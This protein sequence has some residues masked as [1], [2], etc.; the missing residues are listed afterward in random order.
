MI[1][2]KIS[3]ASILALLGAGCTPAYA[4]E[5]GAPKTLPKPSEPV[6]ILEM[7]KDGHPMGSTWGKVP[8]FEDAN[9]LLCFFATGRPS[10]DW[11]DCLYRNP[12]TGQ[13]LVV[14][15]PTNIKR[16]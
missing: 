2:R 6:L 7:G 13:V 5:S 12:E 16:T 3:L 15:V 10:I 1:A 4:D 14:R 11:I 8:H 9:S